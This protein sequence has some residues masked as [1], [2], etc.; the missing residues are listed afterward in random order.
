MKEN[1]IIFSGPMIK[2]ILEDRKNQTRRVVKK[3]PC[4][5]G[6]TNWI[7]KEISKTTP[8]GWQTV[9]HSGK[10]SCD[11]CMYD[12]V[13]SPYQ[14]G[15]KLWVRETWRFWEDPNDGHDF[16]E[17]R[18]GGKM[19]FPNIDHLKYPGDPFNGKW[20]PSIFMPRWASRITLKVTGILVERL[21][22]ISEEDCIAEGSQILCAELPKSCQ[23]ATMTEKTQFSRIWDSINGKKYPWKDNPFVWVIEFKMTNP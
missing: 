21:Q 15:M 11:C 1:P 2:A 7:P 5:C 10:W 16:V 3:I 9:G 23:Q 14:V 19:S 12:S 20:K 17:Y 22:N 18:A 8:E 13:K 6:D 4:D